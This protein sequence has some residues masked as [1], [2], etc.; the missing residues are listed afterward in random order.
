MLIKLRLRVALCTV[1]C[2]ALV[3]MPE[4]IVDPT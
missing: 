2:S 3:T 4:I 1:A